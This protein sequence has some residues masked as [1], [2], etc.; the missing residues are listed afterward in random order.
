MDELKPSRLFFFFLISILLLTVVIAKVD[1][2]IPDAPLTN[3]SLVNVNS[4]EYWNGL[5][6]PSDI[7]HN[8][9]NNLAWSVAGH[10]MDTNLDMNN[11][12]IHS[13]D[14]TYFSGSDFISSDDNGH[15]DLHANYIDLH[16][17]L[18]TIWMVR[19]NADGDGLGGDN[20]GELVF[21]A[22]RDAYIY[23]NGTDL[24]IDPNAIGSG[25]VIID[26]DLIVDNFVGN[27]SN[28][29]VNNSQYLQGYTPTT[30]K[31]WIQGLFDS[32]YCKLTGCTM[33][34]NIDMDGNDILN[35]GNITLTDKI[36][37][38]FGELIDNLVDGWIKITGNL[39]VTGNITAEN[40]FLPAY[41]RVPNNNSQ[42]VI[43]SNQWVNVTLDKKQTDTQKN[44]NHTWN[45]NTNETI[46][47]NDGGVYFIHYSFSFID[48]NANP[49]AHIGM[50]L[51]K[52]DGTIVK[53]SY[54]EV[55]THRQDEEVFGHHGFDTI[56]NS[57]DKIKVQFTSDYTTVS[58]YLHATFG[59][60]SIV[61]I[62]IHKVSN[63]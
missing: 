1:I 3:Y 55:D 42:S 46:T 30:M 20:Y 7:D 8:L 18:S 14:K 57:G 24:I 54:S 15:I 50:R 28:L 6:T 52:S 11:Y 33:S 10:T 22:G 62:S 41:I 60:G 2:T 26:G 27:G 37:F 45:D 53:G 40:V 38:A 44:I 36:T 35:V 49:D 32:I 16:G 5:S 59:T 39:N 25:A 31:D 56:L 51:L 12:Y 48:S 61:T 4:S 21:G 13:I 34:G 63:I 43:V 47:I 23:Y 17:N 19:L 29:N 58:S 9:L